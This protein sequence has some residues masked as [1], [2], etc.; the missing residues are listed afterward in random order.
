MWLA[1]YQWAVTMGN[2]EFDP[3]CWN[4]A[5]LLCDI[6]LEACILWPDWIINAHAVMLYF[7]LNVSS[8][9]SSTL[10]IMLWGGSIVFF[11]CECDQFIKL[12]LV[13]MIEFM[14]VACIPYG[15]EC[16]VPL[17][18]AHHRICLLTYIQ[19]LL[20][21]SFQSHMHLSRLQGGRIQCFHTAIC[22]KFQR[23]QGA[24]HRCYFIPGAAA[25][26]S[27]ELSLDSS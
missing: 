8:C 3:E 2:A 4:T 10:A 12:N 19:F 16:V 23:R 6:L 5:K 11:L 13:V 18:D 17:N 7:S 1:A 24:S 26:A 27:L 15:V 20:V 21:F 14:L 22:C 9:S 25:Y